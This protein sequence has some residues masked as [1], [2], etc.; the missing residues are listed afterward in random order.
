MSEGFCIIATAIDSQKAAQEIAEMLVSTK[1]AACV[2]ISIVGSTYHWK[3]KVTNSAEYLL[4]IK[5][6]S[7]LYSKV[8]KAILEVHTYKLPEII[9]I[10][11]QNGFQPYLEWIKDSVNL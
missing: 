7:G 9:M 4:L 10:P 2:Q 3:G 8:E 1:L 11:I 5:T 6:T